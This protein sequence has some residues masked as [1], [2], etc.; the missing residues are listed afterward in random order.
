MTGS[1][2]IALWDSA[3][4]QYAAHDGDS[5]YRRL[6]PFLWRQLGDVTGQPVLDLGCGHGWL[7]DKLRLAGATVTGVDGSTALL[8]RAAEAYPQIAFV[9]HDLTA[10]LPRPLQPFRAVV[11][12]M[13][14]MDLPELDALIA[15]ISASLDGVFV[16]SILHPSFFH[17]APVDDPET[18][19]RYRKVTGYLEH[20][21][22]WITTFGG[23]NHYHRPLSWYVDL[24]TRHGLVVTGLHEP[25]TLPQHGR[26]EA[27]WTDYERWFATVPT[28]LAVACRRLPQSR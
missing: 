9:S 21:R 2:D 10:G 13:V 18:G 27:E 24:L 11:A 15:D 25:P 7:S 14:L 20:E 1:D 8:G 17:Q 6:S 22:R 16:F 4:D 12:H 26:P 3:A 19:E 23:H 5:F 28:M